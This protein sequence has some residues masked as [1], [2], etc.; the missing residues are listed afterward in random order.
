MDPAPAPAAAAVSEAEPVAATERDVRRWLPAGHPDAPVVFVNG[1]P[2]NALDVLLAPELTVT[3]VAPR[4]RLEVAVEPSEGQSKVTARV[5]DA[6]VAAS[7]CR[8]AFAVDGGEDVAGAAV[9]KCHATDGARLVI[10]GALTQDVPLSVASNGD[11]ARMAML[12]FDAGD[13]LREVPLQPAAG[14][15]LASHGF[16]AMAVPRQHVEDA[17]RYAAASWSLPLV[18]PFA[19]TLDHEAMLAFAADT[20]DLPAEDV[21]ALLVQLLKQWGQRAL[22]ADVVDKLRAARRQVAPLME[23]LE[24]LAAERLSDEGDPVEAV[25]YDFAHRRGTVPVAVG[26]ASRESALARAAASLAAKARL[27]SAAAAPYAREPVTFLLSGSAG[28]TAAIG[29]SESEKGGGMKALRLPGAGHAAFMRS[30]DVLH[31][32]AAATEWYLEVRCLPVSRRRPVRGGTRG[33]LRPSA[34]DLE[35]I[36]GHIFAAN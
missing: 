15:S 4:G 24:R 9:L 7:G 19:R 25:C 8:E 17:E 26:E 1:L 5:G 28:L 14:A 10:R 20:A 36:L 2:L 12:R 16:E 11:G 29:K 18:S 6:E 13:E 22:S 34:A 27:T 3:V 23:S 21:E 31:G 33:A 30:L 32:P 35:G